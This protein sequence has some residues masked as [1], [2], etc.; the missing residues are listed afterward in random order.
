MSE[1]FDQIGLFSRHKR[2]P[3]YLDNATM[4]QQP[5]GPDYGVFNFANL[6]SV[7]LQGK[8]FDASSQPEQKSLLARFPPNFPQTFPQNS[9]MLT[10]LGTSVTKIETYPR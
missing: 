8:S 5:A 10:F 1:A 6:F 7:V 9:S 3:T 4:G 2:L